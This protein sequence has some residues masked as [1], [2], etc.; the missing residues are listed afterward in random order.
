MKQIQRHE[1]IIDLVRKHGY[2]STE[3]LVE[4]FG[5]SPQTI[6]RDL[7]ELA[8]QNKIQRHHGGAAL[9]S[10]S[11]VNAAYHDRKVMRLEEKARIAERVASYIP[12]GAT[13]F[14]D[15]GTTPEAVA[16][17]L[18]NHKN[19][20][21]VTNNLNVA[22]LLTSKPDFRLILAGGEVRSRD[23]GIIGEATLDFISQF[24]LDY[25]IL[26]ISG[27][28]MD[29]SLLEFDYHEVRTKRAIIENSR[30]VML[31]TD[32]SKFGR[33]AMVNLGN[34]GLIDY[35]FT[36]EEPPASV[37]SIIKQYDVKLELC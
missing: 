11:A 13:L 9:P 30:S 35:L 4:H 26:G 6:R 10:S 23:G 25:G 18:L 7:N 33:N 1:S 22:T 21:V 28:D 37:M 15:I 29:G 3:E 14:I 24:R 8:D 34:M 27:I 20:R 16:H 31:V 36:D 17:A 32:H 12:D 5:V 19:L 2:V